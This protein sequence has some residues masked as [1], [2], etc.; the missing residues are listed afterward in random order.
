MSITLAT[1]EAETW[2]IEIQGQSGQK[3]LKILSQQIKIWAQ[4]CMPVIQAMLAA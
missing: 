4:W 2:R 1:Q 3:I